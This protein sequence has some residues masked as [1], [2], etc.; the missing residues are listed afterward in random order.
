[1]KPRR[2]EALLDS[3]WSKRHLIVATAILLAVGLY[4][5][6]TTTP[7]RSIFPYAF[8]AGMVAWKHGVAAGFLFA[9]LGT[10]SALATGAFPSNEALRGHELGE[11]L[12]T[13]LKLSAVVL[14]VALG[15]R[16]RQ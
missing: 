13:Y 12:Y 7:V 3:A 10:L 6:T 16:L 8:A 5:S 4:G 1:M 15:N 9:G 11:G 14:G 2:T